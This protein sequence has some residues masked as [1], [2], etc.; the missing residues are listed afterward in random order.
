MKATPKSC[1]CRH[2]RHA[3]HTKPGNRYV[4]LEERAFRHG[5]N[6]ALRQ[7]SEEIVPAGCRDRL[8]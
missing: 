1:S 7:G 2:C 5:S 4:K 6:Q 8:G 3:K